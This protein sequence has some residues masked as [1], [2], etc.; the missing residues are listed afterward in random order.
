MDSGIT[1][2]GKRLNLSEYNLHLK[3]EIKIYNKKLKGSVNNI[4][5]GFKILAELKYLNTCLKRNKI[6]IKI[7]NISSNISNAKSYNQYKKLENKLNK[8]KKQLIK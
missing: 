7:E 2:N 1:I 3:E 6:K 5:E 8:L 4:Q